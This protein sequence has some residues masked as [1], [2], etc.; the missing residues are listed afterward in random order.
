MAILSIVSNPEA[1]RPELRDVVACLRVIADDIEAG[2]YGE[3]LRAAVVLRSAGLDP[4]VFGPGD[5]LPAQ[6]FMDLHAGAEQI[7]GMSRPERC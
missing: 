5:T 7:M 6:T 3:V 2:R 4:L 1:E